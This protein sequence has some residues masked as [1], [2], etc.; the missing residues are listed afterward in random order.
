MGAEEKRHIGF[1][2]KSVNNMIRRKL[3]IRFADAGHGELTG[4]QGPML[5]F[6]HRESSKR[7]VFQR[8]IE[9]EFNVRR[10][11]ATVMLQNLEQRGYIVR[12]AVDRDARLKKIVLTDKAVLHNI[13]I[14]REIDTFNRELEAGLTS[15]EKEEFLRIL[16]KIKKNLE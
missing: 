13:A 6:I 7:D 15:A 3:D 2:M 14:C 9:K 12:E 8:D 1:E 11:T 5:G 16:D 10:S 4:M